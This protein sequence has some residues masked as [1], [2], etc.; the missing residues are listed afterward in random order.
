MG[1]TRYNQKDFVLSEITIKHNSPD[2]ADK[3]EDAIAYILITK[4]FDAD[5]KKT[6]PK[7]IYKGTPPQ[8]Y[9]ML[10]AVE[11]SMSYVLGVSEISFKRPDGG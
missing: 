11:H 6:L 8:L 7:V 2:L 1:K 10:V 3:T 5:P 4:P 9:E